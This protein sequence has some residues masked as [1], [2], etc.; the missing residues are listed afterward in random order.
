MKYSVL[1]ILFALFFVSCTKDQLPD[2]DA[3]RD[4]IT[5]SG[6][7][8]G[9][10]Y[11]NDLPYYSSPCFNPNNE[12][13]IIYLG[14]DGL[15]TFKLY[16]LNLKTNERSEIL[17]GLIYPIPRWSVKDWIIFS[18][19]DFNVYKIKSNGDSLTQLTDSGN[20]FGPVWNKEGNSFIYHEGFTTPTRGIVCEEDGLVIDTIIGVGQHNWPSWRHDSLIAYGDLLALLTV[21]PQTHEVDTISRISISDAGFGGGVFIFHRLIHHNLEN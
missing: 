3:C 9:P 20:C 8:L 17:E 12:E 18:K 13:E 2:P 15:D 1:I 10:V 4:L 11:I 21:N 14:A 7:H 5:P 6:I 16:K 19:S